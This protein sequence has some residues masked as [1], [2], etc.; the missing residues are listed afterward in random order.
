MKDNYLFTT[1]R[2]RLVLTISGIFVVLIIILTILV[3]AGV[4]GGPSDPSQSQGDMTIDPVSGDTI[5]NSNTEPEG[6][7]LKDTVTVIGFYQLREMGFMNEQYS[8]ILSTTV[9]YIMKNRPDVKQISYKKDSFKYK[10]KEEFNESS[11]VFVT[12]AGESF[13]V[14]LDTKFSIKDVDVVIEQ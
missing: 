8:K 10:S 7:V 4:L 11:F 14:N 2:G 1:K 5:S 6:S 12:D 13:T 3:I 9:S